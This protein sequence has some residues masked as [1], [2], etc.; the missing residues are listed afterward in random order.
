MEVASQGRSG[1]GSRAA[2]LVLNH[3]T[4]VR[5]RVESIQ[6]CPEGDTRRKVSFD[7]A[8]PPEKVIFGRE[9]L[10]SVD[11]DH[12]VAVPF[13]FMRKGSLVNLDIVDSSGRSLSSVGFSENGRI[14]VSA[15][16]ELC[17]LLSDSLRESTSL[18]VL[19]HAFKDVVY[20]K[21]HRGSS[22]CV[23][24]K[25]YETFC[26]TLQSTLGDSDDSL[27]RIEDPSP[28]VR[29]LMAWLTKTSTSVRNVPDVRGILV[30]LLLLLAT[31][32]KSYAFTILIPRD[33]ACSRSIVKVSFDT[34]V[35]LTP[36]ESWL[37][38]P[39][40][41]WRV[42]DVYS[43][44]FADRGAGSTHV[45]LSPT[46]GTD[47][48]LASEQP[49]LDD[50][51]RLEA[52]VVGRRVHI[53]G[54]LA[55]TSPLARVNIKIWA[56]AKILRTVT[57]WS[58]GAVLLI[59]SSLWVLASRTGALSKFATADN[60]L[61]GVTIIFAVWVGIAITTNRHHL[62]SDLTRQVSSALTGLLIA[63]TISLIA[64]AVATTPS[65]LFRITPA[66]PAGAASFAGRLTW[67]WI[68][69]IVAVSG[70]LIYSVVVM[71]KSVRA[72]YER[73][74]DQMAAVK[75]DMTVVGR[76]FTLPDSPLRASDSRNRDSM[77]P[78]DADEVAAFDCIDVLSLPQATQ[79][80]ES[81][82]TTSELLELCSSE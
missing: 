25:R 43:V 81:V 4:W 36:L 10:A 37:R 11:D 73:H 63:M 65:G 48:L 46:D 6:F 15:L 26:A 17:R 14:T 28:D 13:A 32:S 76:S 80:L 67:V 42:A 40:A 53:T 64:V 35:E 12:L 7:I 79:A 5:R 18:A 8:I 56:D 33:Q 62:T 55:R 38:N 41:P 30:T 20:S 78:I 39:F 66:D 52:R 24:K 60:V 22:A 29:E 54:S 74:L 2:W 77:S 61:A 59:A 49:T 69:A 57:A 68:T 19:E 3:P 16:T 1:F 45:E 58:I 70:C 71:G 75:S 47:I 50:D 21:P 31:V 51:A 82:R 72:M 27:P 9:I 44:M 34:D 23:D